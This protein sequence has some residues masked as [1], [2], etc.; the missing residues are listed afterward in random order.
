[1]NE[2]RGILMN[3]E[4]RFRTFSQQQFI[5]V[6]ALDRCRKNSFEPTRKIS[7]IAQVYNYCEHVADNAT[8]KR[9][10]NIFLSLVRDLGEFRRSLMKLSKH[11]SDPTLVRIF[12]QWKRL[13]ES[14]QDISAVRVKFPFSHVNHLSCDEARN[15]FGGV[16]SVLPVAMGYARDAVERIE[17]IRAYRNLVPSTS[18]VQSKVTQTRQRSSLRSSDSTV[19]GPACRF[20]QPAS[21]AI[22]SPV[23]STSEASIQSTRSEMSFQN[24]PAKPTAM[25]PV[26]AVNTYFKESKARKPNSVRPRTCIGTQTSKCLGSLLSSLEQQGPS[27]SEIE[28]KKLIKRRKN[29]L[30]RPEWKP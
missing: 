29:A 30:T 16:V 26:S 24:K 2:T 3:L 5:F 8:D 4:R 12:G 17:V 19:P 14:R 27:I 7:T 20:A 15:H 6:I 21:P 11:S 25:R 23:S 13:L 18:E 9:I 28:L 22:S 1:M 10:F